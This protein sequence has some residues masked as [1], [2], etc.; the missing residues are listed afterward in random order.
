MIKWV[1]ETIVY[2]SKQRHTHSTPYTPL[3]RQQNHNHFRTPYLAHCPIT[4]SGRSK[5][6]FLTVTSFTVYIFMYKN[7][8]SSVD[9]R[10]EPTHT[11]TLLFLLGVVYAPYGLSRLEI[12]L[13][14]GVKL[15]TLYHFL[16][17]QYRDISNFCHLII[18]H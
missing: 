13:V 1:V 8:V 12:I 4:M 17:S 14:R 5:Y 16:S 18:H 9:R 11:L 2:I 3:S 15:S 10:T 7:R 6:L